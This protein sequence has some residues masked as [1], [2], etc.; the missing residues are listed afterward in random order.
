MIITGENVSGKLAQALKGLTKLDGKHCIRLYMIEGDVEQ[1]REKIIKLV[2][3][4][5]PGADT[6]FCEDGE[7]FLL[8]YGASV[9][10][11]KE[12]LLSIAA[13]LGLM[14]GK[15]GEIFN[16]V[17]QSAALLSLL[18][19]KHDS[20]K[21]QE[22][23][24]KRIAQEQAVTSSARKRQEILGQ[25]VHRNATE[26]AAQRNLRS[27]PKLMIIE[28]DPFS[29]RLVEN[30]LQKQ[31]NLTGLSSADDALYTYAEISPDLLFLD[32][33]LPDVTGHELLEKI[34]ALDPKAYVVMLSGNADR[35]NVVQAI[36]RGAVGF[37]AKPFSRDKLFQYI[38][39]CPTISKEK[40]I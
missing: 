29:R 21:P 3:A 32:I 5:L 30:V 10:E 8:T 12:A 27:E 19:K 25:G 9:K 23:D 31:Y 34:I 1:A 37:V 24:T 39:R 35:N 14:P 40:I 17:L 11:C 7:I 13:A 2:Q 15:A 22:P 18:E 16:L 38:D 28:D 26:I 4:Y 36:E 6:Y 20:K 33:N